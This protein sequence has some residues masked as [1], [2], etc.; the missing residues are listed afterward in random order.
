[1]RLQHLGGAHAGGR[2]GDPELEIQPIR[3]ARR[4]QQRFGL[5]RRIVV[6]GIAL[7][8]IELHPFRHRGGGRFTQ[9]G[10][11][12]LQPQITVNRIVDCLAH[13]DIGQWLML[14]ID[15][16]VIEIDARIALNREVAVLLHR[17]DQIRRQRPNGIHLTRFQR[18]NPC[19]IFRTG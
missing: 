18:G 15:R 1:M 4:F 5:I 6:I 2:I 11:G 13:A 10:K 19:R 14:R 8:L 3:V 7:L 12:H 9:T 16:H 17:R